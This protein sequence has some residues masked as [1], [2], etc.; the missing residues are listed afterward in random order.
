MTQCKVC[1]CDLGELPVCFGS[2]S[3][4]S[5]MVPVE[6]FDSRVAENEDLCIIDGEHYYFQGGTLNLL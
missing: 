5:L 4:A 6:E 3:P 1:N 2:S